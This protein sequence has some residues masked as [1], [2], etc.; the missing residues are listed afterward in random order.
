MSL[1]DAQ[2]KLGAA[3]EIAG[4]VITYDSYEEA[5]LQIVR[6]KIMEAMDEIES[7]RSL[8]LEG[9]DRMEKILRNSP[10]RSRANEETVHNRPL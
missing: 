5:K 8:T 7:A 3:L 1:A 10:V 9:L 2:S 4:E 6:S